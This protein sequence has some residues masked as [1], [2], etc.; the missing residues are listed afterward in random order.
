MLPRLRESF[1][2]ER[3][4]FDLISHC[5]GLRRLPQNLSPLDIYDPYAGYK[6]EDLFFSLKKR[7]KL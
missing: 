6:K 4:V 2:G 3:I 5:S 7:K 1:I